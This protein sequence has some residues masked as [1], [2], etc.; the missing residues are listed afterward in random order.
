MAEMP[1]VLGRFTSTR[2]IVLVTGRTAVS[3]VGGI[4]PVARHVATAKRLGF[5]PIV[6]YPA[7]MRALG[8]E[9]AGELSDET[10]CLS[11]AEF[12]SGSV[13]EDGPVLVIAGDWY[14]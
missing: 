4:T 6:V 9:I 5:D 1:P 11:S 12:M 7:R 2:V 13:V 14:V 8:A 3:R 10:P